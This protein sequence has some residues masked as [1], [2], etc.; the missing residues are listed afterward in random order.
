MQSNNIES[1][2][3][4]NIEIVRTLKEDWS[5]HRILREFVRLDIY[6][7]RQSSQGNLSRSSYSISSNHLERLAMS[8]TMHYQ[9]FLFVLTARYR[10]WPTIT[11][12]I[13]RWNIYQAR[14]YTGRAIVWSRRRIRPPAASMDLSAPITVRRFSLYIHVPYPDG[15]LVNFR[16]ICKI[17]LNLVIIESDAPSKL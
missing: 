14:G 5:K 4:I 1:K 16:P 11:G 9:V 12:R 6:R 7:A 2:L 10:L 17:P 8:L 3:I 13:K 15:L